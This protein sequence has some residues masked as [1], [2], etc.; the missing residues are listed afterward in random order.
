[1]RGHPFRTDAPT[2][3]V[4]VRLTDAEIAKVD[5]DAKAAGV[6]RST[7]IRARLLG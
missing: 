4:S 6:D 7:W 5:A 3:R 1:M 2:K